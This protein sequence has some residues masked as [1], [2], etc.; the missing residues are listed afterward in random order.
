MTASVGSS[1][2]ACERRAPSALAVRKEAIRS[3]PAATLERIGQPPPHASSALGLDD[4][5][6]FLNLT[7][8][9]AELCRLDLPDLF[10]FMVYRGAE[11]ARLSACCGPPSTSSRNK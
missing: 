5:P 8:N 2:A 10:E 3:N 1:S 7:R 11:S 4:V 9:D 6:H